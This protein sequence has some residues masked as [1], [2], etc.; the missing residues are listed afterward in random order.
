[1]GLFFFLIIGGI[2]NKKK[3]N[4]YNARPPSGYA[5]PAVRRT[6]RQHQLRALGNEYM[7]NERRFI[8][9]IIIFSVYWPVQIPLT[10]SG[11][12]TPRFDYR[13]ANR[14]LYGRRG[15]RATGQTIFEIS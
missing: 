1:M 12:N 15:R 3:K 4:V 9:I 2:F 6:R 10:G 7:E 8:R 5:A 11:L 14:L 13:L